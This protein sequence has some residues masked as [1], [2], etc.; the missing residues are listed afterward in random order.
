VRTASFYWVGSEAEIGGIRPS[1]WK[2]YDGSVPN[3]A[4]VDSVLSWLELPGEERPRLITLYMSSVDGAGHVAGPHTGRVEDAVLNVDRALGRLM[5][6]IAALPLA[7]SV[8]LVITSDHGMARYEVHQ[9]ELLSDHIDTH[10]SRVRVATSGPFASLHVQSGP[11]AEETRDRLNAG[12]RH[13]RAYLR[14]E[15]PEHLRYREDPR[16]GDVVVIMD[17]PYHIRRSAGLTSG[18]GNHGWDPANESMHGILM[19]VGPSIPARQ[20]IAPVDM[21]DLY[22][23]F[24]EVLRLDFDHDIDGRPSA[25]RELLDGV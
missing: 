9:Y 1:I 3:T 16:I 13:G 19:M 11:S 7:D 2:P 6:G 21:V 20:R 18:G 24:T 4:R 14:Q 8:Y 15:T 25:L 23:F 10:I 22:P 12:L 5:D 17:E